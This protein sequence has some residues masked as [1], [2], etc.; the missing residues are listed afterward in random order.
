MESRVGGGV[1]GEPALLKKKKGTATQERREGSLHGENGHG[2]PEPG[3]KPT[4]HVE[5]LVAVVDG[6]P[7]LGEAIGAVF[8][9]CEEG[10][11]GRAPLLDAAKLGGE[12][13]H[14]VLSVLEEEAVGSGAKR[15]PWASADGVRRG[16]CMA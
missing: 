4:D 1:G 16:W 3:V 12:E 7:E 5:H 2:V 14:L 9:T 11:D 13:H 8:E 15:A 6:G 10:E